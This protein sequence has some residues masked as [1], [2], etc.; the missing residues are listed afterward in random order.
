MFTANRLYYIF[1]LLGFTL[2]FPNAT[3]TGTIND[4]N[5]NKPLIGVN[6]ILL[7]TTKRVEMF[8]DLIEERTITIQTATNYGASTD[9]DGEYI[10][11]NVPAGAVS[12]T[13]LTLPT[14]REV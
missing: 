6:V 13:H 9:M 1:F 14:N 11:N 8:G 5:S 7:E 3:I 4:S 10:I 2:L 12:Y